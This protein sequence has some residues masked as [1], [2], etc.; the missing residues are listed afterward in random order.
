MKAINIG[1]ENT[2]DERAKNFLTEAEISSFL[3]AAR[4]SRH[5]VRNFA[6]MLLG[7]PAWAASE[8]TCEHAGARYRPRHGPTVCPALQRQPVDQSTIGRRRNSGA[9]G[10]VA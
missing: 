4:K 2:V 5:G 6:M 3:K 1:N 7:L 9:A 10:M 8:R